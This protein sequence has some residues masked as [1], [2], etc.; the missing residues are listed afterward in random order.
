MII[1]DTGFWI[2]L[3]F[4]GDD[5]HPQAA[6][7]YRRYKDQLITTWP[8]LTETC[9][10]LRRHVDPQAAAAL[11]EQ[12]PAGFQ[13]WELPQ[14]APRQAAVL[15]RRYPDLP[16]DLADASAVLLAKHLG[17][18]RI[19][20]TDRRDFAAYRWKDGQPFQNK[21]LGE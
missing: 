6:A 17:H 3:L 11:L 16:M 21:L 1:A 2:A 20:S 14:Q 5:Y 4:R 7:A 8:I 19:L 13:V 9:H 10:L 18:G 12:A 15:M